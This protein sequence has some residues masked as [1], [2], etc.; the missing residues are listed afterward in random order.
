MKNLV[1][2]KNWTFKETVDNLKSLKTDYEGILAT[3]SCLDLHEKVLFLKNTRDS[4][5][6]LSNL[7]EWEKDKVWEYMNGFEFLY[8]LKDI[9][10]RRK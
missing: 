10:K 5:Y 3:F 4:F 8:V 6:S 2:N 7:Q 9:A 1:V